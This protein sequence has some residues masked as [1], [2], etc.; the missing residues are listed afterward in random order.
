VKA[1]ENAWKNP[2][3]QAAQE[4]LVKEVSTSSPIAYKLVAAS[5]SAVPNITDANN[6]NLLRTA[7]S[8]AA[9]ALQ[10]LVD[11]NK[12]LVVS[13]G[14][15]LIDQALERF[16]AEESHLVS[17]LMDVDSGTLESDP[18]QTADGAAQLLNIATRQVAGAI[19]T[20]ATTAKANPDDLGNA[21]LVV[22]DAISQTNTASRALAGAVPEKSAQRNILNSAK[23]L[24]IQARNALTSARSVSANPTDPNLNSLLANSAKSLAEALAGLLAAAKGIS[25]VGKECDDAVASITNSMKALTSDIK[26]GNTKDFPSYAEDLENSIKAVQASSQL[27]YSAAKNNPKAVGPSSKSAANTVAP[28]ISAAT[29]TAG[30][31]NLP[32]TSKAI[33]SS[34]YEAAQAVT[35][36]IGSAKQSTSKA[37]DP[38]QLENLNAALGNVNSSL[39][40]LLNALSSATPAQKQLSDAVEEIMRAVEKLSETPSDLTDDMG[41]SIEQIKAATTKLGEATKGVISASRTNPDQMGGYAKHASSA[42]STIVSASLVLAS[43][44]KISAYAEEAAKVKQAADELLT[45]CSITDPATMKQQVIKTA[46]EITIA[47]QALAETIKR[48]AAQSSDPSV[49]QY[50]NF[51]AQTLA[52]A[53]SAVVTAAKDVTVGKPG[54]PQQLKNTHSTVIS[55]IDDLLARDTNKVVSAKATKLLNLTRDAATSTSLMIESSKNV[56]KRPSDS[57]ALAELS[58]SAR[59]VGTAIKGLLEAAKAIGEIDLEEAIQKISQ[60][61]SDLDQGLI[62]STVGLLENTAPANKTT[63]NLE[64]DL[65]EVSRN[66]AGSIKTLVQEKDSPVALAKAARATADFIPEIARIAAQIAGLT[67]NVDKQ[68]DTLGVAKSIADST[69]LLANACKQNDIKEIVTQAKESS[70]AIAKM[71]SNLKGGVIALR[72]CDEASKVIADSLNSLASYNINAPVDRTV[73]YAESQRD[74]TNLA[75]ELVAAI[76]STANVAKTR[77]VEVGEGAKKIAGIVQRFASAVVES[78]DTVDTADSRKDLLSAS[79]NVFQASDR[80][81]KCIKLVAQDSKNPKNQQALSA[82]NKD[83]T[84]SVSRLVQSIKQAATGEVKCEEAIDSINRRIGELDSAALYAATGEL[85]PDS[86]DIDIEQVLNDMND[87]SVKIQ[88]ALKRLTSVAAKN[89]SELGNSAS[90]AMEGYEKLTKEAKNVA[91]QIPSLLAQQEILTGAKAV[92]ITIQLAVTSGLNVHKAPE[93]AQLKSSLNDASVA[94]SDSLKELIAVT[95]T[96]T[97]TSGIKDIESARKGVVQ[98]I[99]TFEELTPNQKAGAADVLKAAKAITDSVATIYTTGNSSDDGPKVTQACNELKAAT[100]NIVQDA[101][102][103]IRLTNA[104][105]GRKL[106]EACKSALQSTASFLEAAKAHKKSTTPDTHKAV[107]E[108]TILVIY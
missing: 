54:A 101:K 33:I 61:V 73:N 59:S 74:L 6:K 29:L 19:K 10:K 75:K 96:A 81:I 27:L 93:N 28:L 78:L 34:A 16:A 82:T 35:E 12:A 49:Q 51:T 1:L 83:V 21:S 38:A 9:E 32:D 66:L 70:Q 30:A 98:A 15:A 77:P 60:A 37:N 17:A 4:A 44:Q 47:T 69:L 95:Q 46:K 99:G 85:R 42:I 11:A 65:V 79:Q 24:T 91:S 84:E 62:S 31:C 97:N 45:A 55:V 57:E 41:A 67:T 56:H 107:S 105:N 52:A 3:D 13:S 63:Q 103:A 5:R 22:A 18:N 92:G 50:L 76:A 53:T 40:K 104:E 58:Q 90:D 43:S 39:D 72:E 20:L 7:A 64:E 26:Q 14:Q 87:T 89:Q 88:D 36:L 106:V 48:D 71:L 8:E 25:T 68:Q 102:G 94:V 108:G 100:V 80:L 2:D 23:E 86:D